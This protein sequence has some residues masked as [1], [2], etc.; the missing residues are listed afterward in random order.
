MKLGHKRVK[1]LVIYQDFKDNKHESLN[2]NKPLHDHTYS[3]Q[4]LKIK[5][6]KDN[7]ML[8]LDFETPS[9]N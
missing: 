7:K 3:M 8:H 5:K 2:Y 1:V 4:L 6:I 9:P